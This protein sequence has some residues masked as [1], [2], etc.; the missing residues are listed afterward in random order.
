M[1]EMIFE[2][3]PGIVLK[4]VAENTPAAATA[5]RWELSIDAIARAV[6]KRR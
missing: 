5:V 3:I 6:E 2:L 1:A 4:V